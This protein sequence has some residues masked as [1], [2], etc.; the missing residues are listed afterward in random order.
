MEEI[1]FAEM[2]EDGIGEIASQLL[3]LG[4]SRIFLF[5]GPMGAG[6]TTLIKAMCVALGSR[7]ELSSPTFAIVNEYARP[8]GRIFH[9]DLYRLT[10][11][12]Q[13]SDIGFEEY[14]DSGEYCLIEWPQLALGFIEIPAFEI[15]IEMQGHR[16]FVRA[17][18]RQPGPRRT[19]A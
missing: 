14:L 8:G 4:E 10:G 1:F 7:D 15:N 6:K 3:R 18:I 5:N 12:S 2:P 9:F 11:P 13:L 16:R 19:F 17:G